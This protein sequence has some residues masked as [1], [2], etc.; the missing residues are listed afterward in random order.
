MP[1][2]I[3][4]PTSHF[5]PSQKD[6][7]KA[8]DLSPSTVGFALN[9]KH[10]H[11]LL[12]ETVELVE[13]MARKMGYRPMRHARI[14]REGRSHTIGVV[15]HSS[16]YHAPQERLRLLVRQTS[17]AGYRLIA[18]AVDWFQPGPR[19]AQDYLLDAAVEGVVLC[20]LN[21]EERVEWR[22]FLQKRS[23]PGVALDHSEQWG[24]DATLAD[25]RPAIREMTLHHLRRGS[26]RVKYLCPFRDPAVPLASV[27]ARDRALG[28]IEAV[29]SVGGGLTVDP[30]TASFLGI[31]PFAPAARDAVEAEIVY[32]HR[33]EAYANAFDVGRLEVAAMI[34]RGDLPDSLVCSNDQ[35][36][37][38]ALSTLIEAGIPVPGRVKLSGVDDALIS[39]YCGVP[40]STIAQPNPAMADWTIRRLVELIE[41]PA[42]RACPKV[43][44]FPC[45]LVLRRSTGDGEAPVFTHSLPTPIETP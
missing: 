22:H 2:T 27:N 20:S 25:L 11:K 28:F 5:G 19:A 21:L 7:A 34:R 42:E 17:A 31:E 23:L 26:R 29:R 6:I 15:Y 13:E 36:A 39:R 32:P 35:L 33:T 24:G 14:L 38:G 40:L 30:D 4:K 16:H 12:P 37:V 18:C 41:N 44:S 43:A 9:P 8:L 3:A 45:E 10:R 1:P